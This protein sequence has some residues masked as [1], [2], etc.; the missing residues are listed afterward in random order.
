MEDEN[1]Q[2]KS[3][4]NDRLGRLSLRQLVRYGVRLEGQISNEKNPTECRVKALEKCREKFVNEALAR[5]ET[6]EN[7]D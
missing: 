4:T 2:I 7:I 3:P 1:Y 5:A 6:T